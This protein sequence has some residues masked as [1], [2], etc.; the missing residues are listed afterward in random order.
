MILKNLNHCLINLETIILREKIVR[1]IYNIRNL[2]D[3]HKKVFVTPYLDKAVKKY[4][5]KYN[6]NEL[7][8]PYQKHMVR[9][10]FKSYFNK[11]GKVKNHLNLQLDSGIR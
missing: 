6:W 3:K 10:G 8:K 4:F 7:N 9:D 2:S 1:I 5:Y 11:V